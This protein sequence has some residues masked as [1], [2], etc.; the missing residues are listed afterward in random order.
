M[1]E[2]E[3]INQSRL[4]VVFVDDFCFS[5]ETSSLVSVSVAIAFSRA[6]AAAVQ[7]SLEPDFNQIDQMGYRR[8]NTPTFTNDCCLYT[9]NQNN[10]IFIC[11]WYSFRLFD[12]ILVFTGEENKGIFLLRAGG[13]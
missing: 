10:A 12:R 1:S 3:L 8:E 2:R 6:S 9:F 13:R 11:C 4:L 7:D 5:T